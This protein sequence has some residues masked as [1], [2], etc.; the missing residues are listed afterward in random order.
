MIITAI[1]AGTFAVLW[2]VRA[3]QVAAFAAAAT[4]GRSRRRPSVGPSERATEWTQ[5]SAPTPPA[6][7]RDAVG[8]VTYHPDYQ[9]FDPRRAL[10][11][12]TAACRL[13]VGWVR[14]DIRWNYV[15][16]DGIRPDTGALSWYREFLDTLRKFQL[17]SVVVLSS[18]PA[19]V[20]TL[21]PQERIGSWNR[22]VEI[23]ARELGTHCDVFQLMNEINN[24]AYGFLPLKETADA[25]ARGAAIVRTQLPQAAIAINVTTD[26]WGWQNY[27]ERLLDLS[28]RA[29]DMIGLDHYP[30]TWSVGFDDRWA[31]IIA[32]ARLIESAPEGSPWHGRRLVVM[33]TGYST[34]FIGR[35]EGNQLEYF[36]GVMEVARSLKAISH[37]DDPVLGIYEL[38]DEDSTSWL[39]PEAHFGLLTSDLRPKRAF[40]LVAE[41]L[42]SF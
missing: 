14:T 27:L 38:C 26:L 29:V 18:P 4:A 41:A 33:E 25:L 19:G 13:G 1:G 6:R 9:D 2:H 21:P 35:G 24:P 5:V 28:G 32:L 34:N 8:L 12:L 36:R 37:N 20:T 30:G 40:A 42:Q 15:L 39:D 22:F 3:I 17:K 31:K 10:A 7:A 16:P 11:S 23:T